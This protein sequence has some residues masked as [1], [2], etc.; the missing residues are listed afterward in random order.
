MKKFNQVLILIFFIGIPSLLYAETKVYFSPNGGCMQAVITEINK[1]NQSIEVAMYALTSRE[2]S[3][4]LVEAKNRHVRVRIALNIS[5]I[6]DPYS[7]CK[8]LES[9]GLSVKFHMGPGFLNDKFAVIDNRVVLTGS[10]NWS[11]V[12]DRSNFENLLVI[13]D[14]ELALKYARQFKLLWAKCGQGQI[15]GPHPEELN[16]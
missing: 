9:K 1:A 12:A 11:L 2:I 4:A 14:R 8:F 13:K 15:K 6:M 16:N 7:K 10:Y 5:Q 3:H